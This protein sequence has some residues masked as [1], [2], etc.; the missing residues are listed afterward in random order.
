MFSVSNQVFNFFFLKSVKIF[1]MCIGLSHDVSFDRRGRRFWPV[2]LSSWCR[3]RFF[4]LNTIPSNRTF[5]LS[6]HT[7]HP[8]IFFSLSNS[9]LIDTPLFRMSSNTPLH[10]PFLLL[11]IQGVQ[12]LML[13]VDSFGFSCSMI[14]WLLAQSSSLLF[15]IYSTSKKRSNCF[16]NEICFLFLKKSIQSLSP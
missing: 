2:L 12:L 14:S 4:P 6:N 13:V 5:L 11:K 15:W 10:C 8:I 9:P 1:C 3:Y 16:N 7:I